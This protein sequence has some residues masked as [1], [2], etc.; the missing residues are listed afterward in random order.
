MRVA[1]DGGANHLLRLLE[2]DALS[3]PS[4]DTII[5]DL[6]SLDAATRDAWSRSFNPPQVIHDTDQNSTD[7]GKAVAH[8]RHC[9][10]GADVVVVGDLGGR[11][12][13]AVSIL[14][15]LYLLQNDKVGY[16]DGRVYFVTDG[17][18][19]VLLKQGRHVIRVRGHKKIRSDAIQAVGIL[20]LRE[21]SVITTKGLHWD[22]QDWETQIGS[23]ISTSNQVRDG[24]PVV[25]VETSADV[26]FTVRLQYDA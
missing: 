22:V 3:P 23:R 21:K 14:H 17:S 18:V 20:P 8:I 19:A 2:T 25:E 1:A 5:G 10:P 9:R 26:L 12:D 15:H 6:D 24:E 13:Q 4:L 7:L 11:I 16:N